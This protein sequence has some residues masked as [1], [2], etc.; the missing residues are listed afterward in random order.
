M[1]ARK[2]PGINFD[3]IFIKDLVFHRSPK[4]SGKPEIE[5]DFKSKSGFSTDKTKLMYEVRALVKDKADT[6]NIDCT[7]IG[8][9]SI[10]PGEENYPLEQFGQENAAALIFPYIRE[11]IASVTSKAGIPALLLPPLNIHALLV[12]A[13]KPKQK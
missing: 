1:D 2:Q 7:M 6:F 13:N 11:T 9:F 10:N 3:S 12:E 4:L 8:I 5:M